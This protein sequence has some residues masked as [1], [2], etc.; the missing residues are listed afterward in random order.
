MFC[1]GG[2]NRHHC[3][4]EQHGQVART[5]NDGYRAAG[6]EIG[7]DPIGVRHRRL[8]DNT[9]VAVISIVT[10][11]SLGV[12]SRESHIPFPNTPRFAGN[13]S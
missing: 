2:I 11:D 1:F 4:F 3:G 8:M 10:A 13:R 9:P 6:F 5:L 12:Y 7:N